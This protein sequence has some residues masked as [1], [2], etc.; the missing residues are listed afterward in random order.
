MNKKKSIFLICF[1][2]LIIL[3]ILIISSC[4]IL[5]PYISSFSFKNKFG[6]LDE[7]ANYA[8]NPNSYY[9]TPSIYGGTNITELVDRND[10]YLAFCSNKVYQVDDDLYIVG[11]YGVT[12]C[13][14]WLGIYSHSDYLNEWPVDDDSFYKYKFICENSEKSIYPQE[15]N[16]APFPTKNILGY[17]SNVIIASPHEINNDNEISLKILYGDNYENQKTVTIQVNTKDIIIKK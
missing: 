6:S 5:A 12:N 9:L 7:W 14:M 16:T 3:I 15:D 11:C 13:Y 10:T 17:K 8:Q 4:F 2:I 1:I